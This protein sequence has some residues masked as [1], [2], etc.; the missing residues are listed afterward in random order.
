MSIFPVA[1]EAKQPKSRGSQIAAIVLVA[2]LIIMVVGQLFTYEKFADVMN[3]FGLF[4]SKGTAT[5]V[6]ALIVT[7]EVAALPF[8]LR[9]RLSPLARVISM[10]AGWGVLLFWLGLSCYLNITINLAPN[11][12]VLGDTV[13]LPIEWWMVSFFVALGTLCAW[14]SY[15]LWPKQSIRKQ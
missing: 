5:I 7:F 10:V 14:A 13:K 15:G 1:T 6:A 9:M 4:A 11:S 8:L 2:F 3:A 12:G